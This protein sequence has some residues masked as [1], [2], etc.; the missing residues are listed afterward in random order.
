MMLEAS[1]RLRIDPVSEY[2]RTFFERRLKEPLI[3]T[4]IEAIEIE[5]YE[6]DTTFTDLVGDAAAG[7]GSAG[8]GLADM[9][10]RAIGE[11][12]DEREYV[13]SEYSLKEHEIQ[14]GRFSLSFKT[15][16]FGWV[17]YLYNPNGVVPTGVREILVY[18]EKQGF[19]FRVGADDF[20]LV[21]HYFSPESRDADLRDRE[22]REGLSFASPYRYDAMFEIDEDGIVAT[23]DV[24]LRVL[25]DTD[26][27]GFGVFGGG[28]LRYAKQDLVRD[29]PHVPS[30][31]GHEILFPEPLVAGETV[32]L[33]IGYETKWPS[34]SG[35]GKVNEGF[36][37][38]PRGGFLPFS[39]VLSDPSFMRFVIRTEDDYQHISIGSRLEEEITGGHRYTEWAADYAVNFPTIIIG[40]YYDPVV[41][42]VDGVKIT[43]YMTK[44]FEDG[45]TPSRDDMKPH[46]DRAADSLRLFADLYGVP[47]P[48]DELKLVGTPSQFL[49]A[50][51]P[52]SIVYVGSGLFLPPAMQVNMFESS[53]LD[54]KNVSLVT[55][56]EIAH[57][58]WGGIV[59]NRNN[60]HYWF[61][62][63]MA[64][65]GACYYE[66]ATREDGEC[67]N[68][69]SHWRR[70]TM[71]SDWSCAIHED[72]FRMEAGG[73]QPLRYTKGPYVMHMLEEYFGE[74]RFV[75]FMRNVFE[76][77]AGDLIST[78]DLQRTAEE[79]FQVDMS[80]FFDAWIRGFGVPKVGYEYSTRQAEDGQNWVISGRLTQVVTL[81]GDEKQGQIFENLLV[82]IE[83][84]LASGEIINERVVL[85]GP[86]K[87]FDISVPGKPRTIK[88]NPDDKIIMEVRPI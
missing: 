66:K 68:S 26:R 76:N 85:D 5:F 27:L 14:E 67:P 43:G 55:P 49:S 22:N 60:D 20:D 34:G 40:K 58:W 7:S 54:P 48:Y 31:G 56:H 29:L 41:R 33:R 74:R 15:K 36:W 1:G 52:S 70:S 9:R 81:K 62:E 2:E 87:P 45:L 75:E 32:R 53:G 42:E 82:P 46:V 57:Q 37:I 78:W 65:V 23:V 6:G 86:E 83:I 19:S 16:D 69:V 73:V 51:S 64:D 35:V 17:G 50:Q 77:H 80:W 38:I 8:G 72:M 63:S 21:S 11:K 79:T 44:T 4:E 39:G 71:A 28:R 84:E 3:D 25:I 24:D 59:S 10:K 47:Y 61:V 88:F 12:D 30:G 18:R 13:P